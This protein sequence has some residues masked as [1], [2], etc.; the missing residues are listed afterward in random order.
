[1]TKI[2]NIHANKSCFVVV[3]CFVVVFVFL[4]FVVVVFCFCF[5]DRTEFFSIFFCC[6][7]VHGGTA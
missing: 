5:F 6:F 1:M 3:V 7:R 4:F 2:T